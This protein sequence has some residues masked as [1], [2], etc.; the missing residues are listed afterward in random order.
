MC[1]IFTLYAYLII[2]YY[3]CDHNNCVWGYILIIVFTF[4]CVFLQTTSYAQH[5]D[6]VFNCNVC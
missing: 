4:L 6:M 5:V 2:Y 1:A 3:G